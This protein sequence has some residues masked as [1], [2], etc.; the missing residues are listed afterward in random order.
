MFTGIWGYMFIF[1]KLQK[2]NIS[3]S[4]EHNNLGRSQEEGARGEGPLNCTW[5]STTG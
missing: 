5:P 4:R 1:W 3:I 2:I